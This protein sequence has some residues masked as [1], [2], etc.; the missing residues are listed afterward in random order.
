VKLEGADRALGGSAHSTATTR[1][2]SAPGYRSANDESLTLGIVSRGMTCR[3]FTG[4]RTRRP[5]I[6]FVRSTGFG[7]SL[8][9]RGERVDALARVHER[10]P[11]VDDDEIITF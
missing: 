2:S 3:T 10:D 5:V 6:V 8:L 7:R 1:S 9:A 4:A 11:R